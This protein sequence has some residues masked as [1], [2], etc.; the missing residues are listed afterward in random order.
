MPLEDNLVVILGP[1]GEPSGVGVLV[2]AS[3]ALTCAHVVNAA[4]GRSEYSSQP[5]GATDHVVVRQHGSDLSIPTSVVQDSW[6]APGIEPP[7]DVCLL[8]LAKPLRVAPASL[9]HRLDLVGTAFRAAGVPQGWDVDFAT[10]GVE[11]QADNGTWLLRPP[12]ALRSAGAFGWLP[13]PLPGVITE[14]FSGGPVEV[15]GHI[16]GIVVARRAKRADLTAYMIPA[17]HFPPAVRPPVQHTLVEQQF[18]HV[19]MLIGELR[20][21]RDPGDVAAFDIRV[22]QCN[23]F[24]EVL[25]SQAKSQSAYEAADLGPSQYLDALLSTYPPGKHIVVGAGGSGKSSFLSRVIEAAPRRKLVPFYLDFSVDTRNTALGADSARAL[26]DEC[27]ARFGGRG[28]VEHLLALCNTPHP[29]G[30]RALLVIDGFNEVRRNWEDDLKRISALAAMDLAPATIL[31]ADRLVKRSSQHF[32]YAAIVPVSDEAAVEALS[33]AGTTPPADTEAWR[34]I[35]SAPL[36]LSMLSSRLDGSADAKRYTVQGRSP[37]RFGVLDRFFRTVCQLKDLQLDVLS[38]VAFAMYDKGATRL[39][40]SEFDGLLKRLAG[41]DMSE[42]LREI[43]DKH[44]LLLSLMDNDVRLVALRHQLLQDWLVARK[45]ARACED[46][47]PSLL[48]ASAFDTVS[49]NGASSDALEL[50]VEAVYERELAAKTGLG[51]ERLVTELYDWNAW[52]TVE[53]VRSV[54]QRVHGEGPIAPWIRRAIY[55]LTLEKRF[56]VFLH[57]ALRAQALAEEQSASDAAEFVHARSLEE[58]VAIA[59]VADG[60]NA[61]GKEWAALYSCADSEACDMDYLWK[62]PLFGWTCANVLR[63]TGMSPN[64]AAELLRQYEISRNTADRDERPASF[65]WRIVHALGGAPAAAVGLRLVEIGLDRREQ[66]HVRYGAI[67]S[68]VEVAALSASPEIIRQTLTALREGLPSLLNEGTAT[69]LKQ[70]R[71]VVAVNEDCT[72][73]TPKARRT[74][75]DCGIAEF[76]AL[77]EDGARLEQ[78]KASGVV[79]RWEMWSRMLHDLPTDDGSWDARRHSLKQA[80][81]SEDEV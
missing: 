46:E 17:D 67:R 24:G 59:R 60:T 42:P 37:T 19:S 70:L 15:E 38:D 16:V 53:C 30:L 64:Q 79:A 56:D 50:S 41:P 8:S 39:P 12:P 34:P 78:Q 72:R 4:L 80:V 35:L 58:Q 63:R 54:D 77:M 36:F 49:L 69:Q 27:F 47:E 11:G 68:A 28:S 22:R 44:G 51:V 48:R 26:L 1:G 52:I 5:P 14:R 6:R 33:A 65:R 73:V 75:L 29:D 7:A 3:T 40:A 2:D 76:E 55:A 32:G 9:R 13:G 81:E 61:S 74:W 20:G 25:A 66:R 10:G 43:L 57:T 62:D 71:R 45:I 18:P 31:I 21:P 23:G